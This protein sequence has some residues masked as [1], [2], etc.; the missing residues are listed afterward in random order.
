[1]A[2]FLNY[3]RCRRCER[4]WIDEWSC[5]CDDECRF[6]GANEVSPWNSDDLT[7]IIRE[8]AG[9]FVVLQSPPTA[10]DGPAYEPI[11][12]FASFPEAKAFFDIDPDDRLPGN[13]SRKRTRIHL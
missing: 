13:P 11:A 7:E 2:W 10:T 5:M 8:R 4:T 1:M 9:R 12:E 6:C 3:Y